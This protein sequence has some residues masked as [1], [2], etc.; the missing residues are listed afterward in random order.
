MGSDLDVLRE[1]LTAIE[2]RLR[3][4]TLVLI[5]YDLRER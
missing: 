5:D 3:D 1:Q 2:P 4:D